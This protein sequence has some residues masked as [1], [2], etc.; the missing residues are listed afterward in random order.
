MNTISQL[1]RALENS[2]ANIKKDMNEIKF[3]IKSQTEQY[4]NIKKEVDASKI[5]TVTTDKL[6]ILKI[7]IGEL[8]EGL[9]KVWDLE[10]QLRAMGGS[11]TLQQAIDELSIKFSTLNTKIT[12]I[13]K[14]NVSELQFKTVLDEINSELNRMHSH[15][16]EAEMKRD[17][18]RRGDIEHHTNHIIKK[19]NS[20]NDNLAVL[21]KEIK[22]YVGKED[23][24]NI[25]NDVGKDFA[26]IRKEIESVAKRDSTFIKEDEVKGIL[27]EINKE[28]D[29][30]SNEITGLKKQNKEN[31]TA[32]QIK[33]LIDDIS[34]EF[35]DLRKDIVKIGDVKNYTTKN[36]FED[37]RKTFSDMQK[38]VKKLDNNKVSRNEFERELKMIDSELDKMDQEKPEDYGASVVLDSKKPS[39]KIV[40]TKK[41]QSPHKSHK[42]KYIFGNILIVIAFLSLIASIASFYMGE[43]T[44]MDNFAIAAVSSFVVGMVFRAYAIIKGYK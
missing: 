20:T 12:E 39:K 35:N 18:I 36:E 22:N 16:R 32:G 38:E 5:D 11:K 40:V 17:E 23:M 29:G 28:F 27:N 21:R 10:K 31:V 37:L 1:N 25:L 15:I 30:L 8:N 34:S 42:G 43:Q 33:G 14:R 24:K 41:V 26:S 3:S 13:D 7:K 2:F 19:I 4:S 9:K 44:S 6:N